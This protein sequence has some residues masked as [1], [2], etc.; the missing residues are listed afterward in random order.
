[1]TVHEGAGPTLARRG[2]RGRWP[3][4]LLA[5]L[6]LVL[7]GVG[8][9]VWT[10]PAA[11]GAEG[12]DLAGNRVRLDEGTVPTAAQVRAMDAD[13]TGAGRFE[14]PSVALDV[15]LGRISEADGVITPPGFTSAYLVRNRGVDPAHA[16]EGTVYVVMHSLSGRGTAPG[17]FL[18][19]ARTG[20]TTLDVGDA[21]VVDGTE[22]RVTGS[23]LVD[24][25]ALGSAT[26]VWEDVPGRLVVVTCLQRTDGAPSRQNLLVYAELSAAAPPSSAASADAASADAP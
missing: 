3:A 25:T 13:A 8:V 18:A 2:R 21:I 1:M 15:D 10:Q 4:V 24:K 16:G 12:T 11:V 23:E 5:V 14:V 6:G 26:H 20:R 19:D 22:F 7:L 17:D 9:R